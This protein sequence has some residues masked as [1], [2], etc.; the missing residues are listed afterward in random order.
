MSTGTFSCPDASVSSGTMQV[1][2]TSSASGTCLPAGNYV[3]AFALN[4]NAIAY[5][6]GGGTL[7]YRRQ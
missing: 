5:N 7:Q 2:I 6:C 3:C 1:S 4:G